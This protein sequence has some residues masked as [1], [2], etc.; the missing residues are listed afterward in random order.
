MSRGKE[1][2]SAFVSQIFQRVLFLAS[3]SLM[4]LLLAVGCSL[5]Y[6]IDD[7][8]S[9]DTDCRSVHGSGARC[10]DGLCVMTSDG[11]ADGDADGDHDT[12]E[13]ADGDIDAETDAEE[14]DAE[15]DEDEDV[16]EMRPE[17]L[18]SEQC[19][20]IIGVELEEALDDDVILLG[21]IQPLT[22][23]LSILGP[24]LEQA[25]ELAIDEI[26]DV[27]GI[28]GAKFAVV[29]CDSGTNPVA[30]QAAA[31]H[32]VEVVGVP[33]VL[34]P[35]SSLIVIHA[36]NEVFREAGVAVVSAGANS[37]VMASISA[38][39][40]I[41]STSPPAARMAQ[42][43]AELLIDNG[44]ERIGVVNRR[45]PWGS[46]MRDAME[47][48]L[49]EVH[50]CTEE[51]YMAREYDVTD[52]VV[53]QSEALADLTRFDPEVVVAMTYIEDGLALLTAAGHT[54][55]NRFVTPDGL[56]DGITVE[57]IPHQEILC[58]LLGT[59]AEPP[60]GRVFNAF[61]IRYEARW[62]VDIVPYTSNA[63]DATYMLAYALSAAMAGDGELTGESIAA[64]MARLSSGREIETGSGNWNIGVQALRSSESATIDYV[65]ASGDV[66]FVEGTGSVLTDV[67]A[68]HFNLSRGGPE[69]LGTIYTI[70]GTY[71]PPN[72]SLA[73]P[74]PVC[75][76]VL[77]PGDPPEE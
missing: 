63:Y 66:D 30:A 10:Q 15:T 43:I 55:L 67:E 23:D 37:P 74:D 18:L 62:G 19:T 34:G 17:D 54:P 4:A 24:Y 75:D 72:E 42:A 5:L 57:L 9:S 68:W 27:G 76:E 73:E 31:Q 20:R 65:G 47:S 40:L 1:K 13:E 60:S 61:R 45:D 36:F 71:R 51:S 39:G 53:S 22:G 50:P 49:C 35:F 25:V 59:S 46:G 33:A 69:S 26:N 56:R 2:K 58:R 38:E 70:D 77:D 12:D 6:G 3:V 14:G 64:A 41:W 11:D 28:Y 16:D 32:L 29:S 8:C 21:S 7:E 44:Y 48:R 52:Y